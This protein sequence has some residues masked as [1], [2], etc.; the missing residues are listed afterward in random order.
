[1]SERSGLGLT[2]LTVLEA[3]DALTSGRPRAFPSCAKVLGEID[4][5]IGL[6][7]RYGYDLLLDL[8]RPW[9]VPVRLVAFRGN[10]GEPGDG[11]PAAGPAYTACRLSRAAEVALAAERHQ[12]A[13]VPIGLIT[14]TR[15]RST[16][17]LPWDSSEATQ[18]P[19]EALRVLTTLRSLVRD[20]GLSDTNI[21]DLV[22]PPDFLTDCEVSGDLPAL[23]E[24]HPTSLQ[25][26]GRIT[27]ADEQHL[28]IESLPPDI[29]TAEALQ[30]IASRA[31]RP[32]WAGAFP[33]LDGATH[34]P[35]AD[36]ED[37]SEL[38]EMRLAIT[39]RPGADPEAM[40]ASLRGLPVVAVEVLA[41]FPAPLAQ[42]LRSWVDRHRAEDI[43][44]S[45]AELDS[46][47]RQDRQRER[48]LR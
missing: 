39:L 17:R 30:E 41:A 18:P 9:T 29:G 25:L 13:P 6:G 19:L 5:R 36:V 11:F 21:A 46:A 20:P 42:L 34:L 37:L 27:A 15:Y 44:N 7:A 3:L 10:Y 40:K 32:A 12:L 2:E 38:G 43:A 33:N 22:G 24:G 26:T 14:G 8:A 23:V 48:S 1:M 16:A 47:V 31:S 28:I 35:L 45:L 4:R